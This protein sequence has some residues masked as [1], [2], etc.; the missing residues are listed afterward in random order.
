MNTEI[1]TNGISQESLERFLEGMK[2]Q[3]TLFYTNPPSVHFFLTPRLY[4]GP[5]TLL[6]IF[7][8]EDGTLHIEL[9]G[10]DVPE[11]PND[12]PTMVDFGDCAA[13]EVEP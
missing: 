12:P 13:L 8:R 1:T 5:R 3:S 10:P 6:A 7:A 9:H 11:S 2:I 4:S